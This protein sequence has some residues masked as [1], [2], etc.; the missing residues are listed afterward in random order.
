MF[1]ET[2][3]LLGV[4]FVLAAAL[5]AA[6]SQA[7]LADSVWRVAKSSG[8]VWVIRGEVQPVALNSESVLGSGDNIRT[9]RNGRAMLARGEERI[10]VSPNSAIGIPV[11]SKSGLATTITQQAGS[12]LLEV[13]KKNVKHFE[14]ET[15]YLA[16]VVK[17]TKFQVS[18]NRAGA[19]VDVLDGQVQVSDFKSGQAIVLL[20]GQAA[21]ALANGRGGLSLSGKGQFNSIE[22]GKPRAPG[23][24][25]LSVPNGGL[26]ATN[27]GAN[28][29]P[30][31]VGNTGSAV[32]EATS[33]KN[34]AVQRTANG[35]VR[36]GTALGEVK[37]DYRKV[38]KGLARASGE[39]ASLSSGR[40]STSR[41]AA[42]DLEANGNGG[43][44]NGP[45][46]VENG[47]GNGNGLALGAGNGNGNSNGLAVGVGNGNGNGNGNGLALGVG[48]G[49]GNGLALGVGS[50]NGNGNG[51]AL[52]VG[53][54]NGNGL[55]LGVGNGN[56][57]GLALG[58]GNVLG[59]GVG[60]GHG[61][62]LGIGNGHGKKK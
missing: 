4:F 49:N 5:G 7:A 62:G 52:G 10:L 12:I 15:P 60:N 22:H 40:R 30:V 31:H 38:T 54:G 37:L 1:V 57:N 27:P 56:G 11:E 29:R 44:T 20:P 47:K 45:P 16:A 34:P 58:V 53:N 39:I 13:E 50:G 51:L 9:G 48:N 41:N 55:A 25:A 42:A 33:G 61:L 19:T 8:E 17:G 23:L 26:R 6:G 28:N 59:V 35:T 3:K 43:A 36:I 32:T 2:R 21:K 18:V 24:R 46:V 14:V